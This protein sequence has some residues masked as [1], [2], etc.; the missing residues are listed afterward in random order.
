MPKEVIKIENFEGISG[1]FDPGDLPDG[2]ARYANGLQLSRAPGKFKGFPAATSTVLDITVKQSMRLVPFRGAGD[3]IGFRDTD[4]TFYIWTGLDTGE[5]PVVTS[6]GSALSGANTAKNGVSDGFSVRIGLGRG[7]VPRHIADL[8]SGMEH[9]SAVLDPPSTVSLVPVFDGNGWVAGGATAQDTDPG[10]EYPFKQNRSYLYAV[11]YIYDGVQESPLSIDTADFV[12]VADDDWEAQV[13]I[14]I[15]RPA[16]KPN[17]RIT[18]ICLYRA[19]TGVN[20]DVKEGF[21]FEEHPDTPGGPSDPIPFRRVTVTVDETSFGHFTLVAIIEWADSAWSGDV[22]TVNDDYKIGATFRNRTGFADTLEH[23]NMSYEQGVLLDGFHIISGVESLESGDDDAIAEFLLLRSKYRRY[24]TFDWSS[25]FYALPS[26]PLVSIVFNGRLYCFDKG[27]AYVV[28][29]ALR[30]HETKE[31]V[32][33]E[34]PASVIA[35]EVG[36]MV[37]AER[38][39]WFNDGRGFNPVGDPIMELIDTAGVDLGYLNKNT[40]SIPTCIYEPHHNVFLVIYFTQTNKANIAIYSPEFDRWTFMDAP[41]NSN[42]LRPGFTSS[43]GWAFI[44]TNVTVHR[45]FSAS[46]TIAAEFVSKEWEMDPYLQTFY[47]I[48]IRGDKP[49]LT[50]SEDGAADFSVT[51]TTDAFGVH[52]G[53]INSSPRSGVGTEWNKTTK[54]RFILTMAVDDEIQDIAIS[55]RVMKTPAIV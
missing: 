17:N 39:I 31:G 32:G 5:T 8:G 1:S 13:D 54:G 10:S 53:T 37:A 27:R 47:Y 40:A 6:I 52:R 29:S 34:H 18:H 42:S 36:M 48:A 24:D 25:D 2:A 23:M 45:L 4:D 43:T 14:P 20:R 33:C 46:T 19:D 21:E 30:D 7:Q 11:S 3:M 44:G 38:Q 12:L 26:K 51:L 50:W 49:I 22:Y 41:A 55:R 35:T 15:T 16:S 28:T 9:N